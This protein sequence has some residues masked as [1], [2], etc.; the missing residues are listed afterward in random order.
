MPFI[1]KFNFFN[2]EGLDGPHKHHPWLVGQEYVGTQ[3]DQLLKEGLIELVPGP[4][5]LESDS[6]EPKSKG[7]KKK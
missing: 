6:L 1:V 2:G 3:S 4:S 7:G 5:E